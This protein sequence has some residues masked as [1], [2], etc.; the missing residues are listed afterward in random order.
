MR[1]LL[2]TI[3]AALIAEAGPQPIAIPVQ[4]AS[5]EEP[6]RVS[7]PDRSCGFGG[8]EVPGWTGNVFAY[9]LATGDP[10]GIATPFPDGQYA[11]YLMNT[12][13]MQDLGIKPNDGVYVLTAW[14]ANYNYWYATPYSASLAVGDKPP[15][16]GVIV[17]PKIFCSTS[18]LGTRGDFTEITLV[19]PAQRIASVLHASG[20]LMIL[21]SS[22]GPNGNFW[23]VLIDKVSLI[24]MPEG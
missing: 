15:G 1:K 6:T 17:T 16:P 13:M 10:C 21:F 20:N 2:F 24:F 3:F 8:Y 5:F 23:P 9:R 19:C 11:A 14:I 12:T 4:N 7:G 22:E 18:G